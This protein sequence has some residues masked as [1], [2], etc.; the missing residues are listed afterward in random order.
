MAA[1]SMR[2]AI[3][4]EDAALLVPDGASVMIGGFLGVGTPDRL[5]DALVARNAR[6]LTAIA[7]PAT[8]G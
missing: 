1:G 7:K 2:S 3:R 4:A 5:L 6:N 8:G